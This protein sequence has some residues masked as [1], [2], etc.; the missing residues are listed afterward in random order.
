MRIVKSHYLNDGK[1][2]NQGQS[3]DLILVEDAGDFDQM[4]VNIAETNFYDGDYLQNNLGYSAASLKVENLALAA[5]VQ[6]LGAQGTLEMGCGKGDVIFLL[7]QRGHPEV[8]GLD[9]SP[10]IVAQAWPEIRDRVDCGDLLQLAPRYREKSLRFHTFC[11]FDIWEHLHPARLHQYI[12]TMLELAEEDAVFFF[13]VPGYGEDRVWGE[14][15]PMEFEENRPCFDQRVPFNHLLAANGE[16]PIPVNGHL[17]WAHTEWWEKLFVGHGLVRCDHWE[18]DIHNHFNGFL[19]WSLQSFYI[20]RRDNR[21]AKRRE[22][23]INRRGLNPFRAWH[24][25]YLLQ[26]AVRRHEK[27]LGR[28]IADPNLMEVLADTNQEKMLLDMNYAIEQLAKPWP[29]RLRYMAKRFL[30]LDVKLF[31]R[32]LL[33]RR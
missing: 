27:Q 30:P 7:N 24:E 25:M 20:F 15:F 2:F 31:L 3:A 8:R 12:D 16:R 26:R 33:G 9:V 23:R 22:S 19:H 13:V 32:R 28:T 17:T 18:T 4:L 1:L 5:I 14:L 6:L 10:Q 21:A 11:G 29:W